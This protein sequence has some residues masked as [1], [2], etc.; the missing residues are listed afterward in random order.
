MAFGISEC[1]DLLRPDRTLTQ[2]V[3]GHPDNRSLEAIA[4]LWSSPGK[5]PPFTFSR[6]AGQQ[7]RQLVSHRGHQH[8]IDTVRADPGGAFAHDEAN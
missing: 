3:F 6:A 4:G 5:S 7:K 1:A 8:D 2:C